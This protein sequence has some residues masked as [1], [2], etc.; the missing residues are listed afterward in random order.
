L[1]KS[2]ETRDTSIYKE[3]SWKMT[4]ITLDDYNN[5]QIHT[6]LFPRMLPMTTNI[7]VYFDGLCQP[8][9]ACYSF[10]IKIEENTIHSEYE[11][12]IKKDGVSD[13]YSPNAKNRAKSQAIELSLVS[14]LKIYIYLLLF[15]NMVDDHNGQQKIVN[16]DNILYAIKTIHT[17]EYYDTIP[18]T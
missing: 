13:E 14:R 18:Q 16:A 10:I 5:S 3:V 17:L 2:W 12:E 15:L 4:T 1:T 7:Q 9:T 6:T 8:G 11:L